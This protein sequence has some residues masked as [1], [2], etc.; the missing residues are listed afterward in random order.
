MPRTTIDN[1]HF[2][3]YDLGASRTKIADGHTH[4]IGEL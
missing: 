4:F 2:H 1:G 3:R